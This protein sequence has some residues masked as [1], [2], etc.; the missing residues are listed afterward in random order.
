MSYSFSPTA[1][2]QYCD[3]TMRT[4]PMVTLMLVPCGPSDLGGL[5]ATLD[6]IDM[7]DINPGFE[8]RQHSITEVLP[9]GMLAI[10]HAAVAYEVVSG[11]EFMEL[12]EQAELY[13]ETEFEESEEA[14][15]ASMADLY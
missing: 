2:L 4:V 9:N 11:R 3:D 6:R 13:L 15:E 1:I 10:Q 14:E 5:Y 8:P 12:V 7:G